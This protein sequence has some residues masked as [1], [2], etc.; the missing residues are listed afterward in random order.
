MPSRKFG[1][2]VIFGDYSAEVSAVFLC[3]FHP[4]G[5]SSKQKLKAECQ[6]GGNISDSE[7]YEAVGLCLPKE[8]PLLEALKVV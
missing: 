5:F 1:D 2:T 4:L 3:C 7:I 8:T 6:G